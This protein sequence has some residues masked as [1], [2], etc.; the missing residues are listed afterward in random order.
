[1]PELLTDPR[2]LR[3]GYLEQVGS[4]VRELEHGC[5]FQN[6][7]FVGMKVNPEETTFSL[8][9]GTGEPI[10]LKYADE[11][12]VANQ[13]LTLQLPAGL[14]RTAGEATQR[15]GALGVPWCAAAAGPVN[16]GCSRS[17]ARSDAGHVWVGDAGWG[18]PA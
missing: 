6:I 5:R 14:E 10:P 15:C 7:D 3:E 8:I 9:P 4:F 11:Y 1:M 2:S 16:E 13:T 12:T 18:L 17:P